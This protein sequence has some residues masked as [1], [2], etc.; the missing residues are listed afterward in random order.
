MTTSIIIHPIAENYNPALAGKPK[1]PD[2]VNDNFFSGFADLLD[3]IN[4]LQ[5]IP[6]V[7]TV[8]SQL[9]GDKSSAAA[10][11]LGGALFG[12]PI[13]LIASIANAIFEQETGNNIGEHLLAAATGK[14]EKTAELG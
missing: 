13:G 3:V 7:S 10:S 9:T 11:I 4:P 1:A 6:G 5:H 12:G 2:I 8:Y 14:Y